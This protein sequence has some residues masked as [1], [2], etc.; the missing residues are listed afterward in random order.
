V[1]EAVDAQDPDVI[2]LRVPAEAAYARLARVAGAGLAARLGFSDGEV[3]QLRLA[4][5]EAWAVLLGSADHDGTIEVT[6]RSNEDELVIE[7]A[8]DHIIRRRATARSMLSD[9][10]L[11]GSVDQHW[12]APDRGRARIRKRH[13]Y[14]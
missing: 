9:R 14:A 6:F 4:I 5:G 8:A 11:S 7:L 12:I 2:T 1:E 3:E 10:V 13:H